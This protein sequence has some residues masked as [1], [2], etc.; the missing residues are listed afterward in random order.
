MPAGPLQSNHLLAFQR[1]ALGLGAPS[2]PGLTPS[3]I[4]AA[5]GAQ[6]YMRLGAF[7]SLS[8]V[9]ATD[10]AG[11]LHTIEGKAQ[12][13]GGSPRLPAILEYALTFRR[14][15]APRVRFSAS[16][17]PLDNSVAAGFAV[18]GRSRAGK[19]AAISLTPGP[20]GVAV[21]TYSRAGGKEHAS[22]EH[23][24]GTGQARLLEHITA[25]LL[26]GIRAED[27][28]ELHYFERLLGKLAITSRRALDAKLRSGGVGLDREGIWRALLDLTQA[29]FAEANQSGSAI[30][31]PRL[32][33]GG[34]ITASNAADAKA[35][36][37]LETSVA[38]TLVAAAVVALG[39]PAWL[40]TAAGGTIVAAGVYVVSQYNSLVNGIVAQQNRQQQ[41][42][43]QQQA[44][45]NA[46]YYAQSAHTAEEAANEAL[47]KAQEALNEGNPT[48]AQYWAQQA[49]DAANSAQDNANAAVGA[50]GGASGDATAQAAAQAA[51]ASA[52]Q[53]MQMAQQ[54]QAAADQAYQN[55]Q[56][57]AQ[58]QAQ[59][60]QQAQQ[61]QAAAQAEA[62]AESEAEA[63]AESEAE[64][65]AEAEALGDDEQAAT[66]EGYQ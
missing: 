28:E 59:A 3:L 1:R 64:A 27:F 9:E 38:T 5:D 60:D 13:A 24:D 12:A 49:W 10:K 31:Q 17:S 44:E 29:G 21:S 66:A 63:E 50:A 58:Q 22:D 25:R 54:A 15:G 36:V 61:Q 6:I 47:Q 26:E 19:C 40:V 52:D 2:R 18:Y 34:D 57:A 32:Y 51:Q 48:S 55:A 16:V 4:E 46:Q 65:E 39:P 37:A 11:L 43:Q 42:Q 23:V 7:N 20:D 33:T 30:P 41:Q 62:E 35:T 14:D 53:A 8:W 56:T 45:A